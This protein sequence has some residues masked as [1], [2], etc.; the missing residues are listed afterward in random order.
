MPK[1]KVRFNSNENSHKKKLPILIFF[2]APAVIFVV[3]LISYPLVKGVAT[4]FCSWNLVKP[5]LG[6]KFIG[7]NNY[8]KLFS[9]T[10]FWNSLKVTSIFVISSVSISTI[11]G[12]GMAL[13]LNQSFKGNE[14]FRVTFLLPMFVTPVVVGI[15]WRFMLNTDLG[16]LNYIL[17]LFNIEPLNWLGNP[18]LALLSV[19]MIDVWEWTPLAFLL[20]LAGLKSLPIE[21]FEAAYVDGANSRDTFKLITLPLMK[22]TLL[23]VIIIRTMDSFGVFDIIYVATKGGPGVS[24]ENLNIYAFIN[25]FEYCHIGYSTTIA[26]FLMITSIFMCNLYRKIIKVNYE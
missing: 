20:C 19:I 4:S 16:L 22:P 10:R 23:S 26:L 15:M 9:D 3:V 2:I 11:L 7:F 12:L 21:P 8:L 17:G 5:Y 6:I 1:N 25:A 24:T 18:T 13:W 14:F